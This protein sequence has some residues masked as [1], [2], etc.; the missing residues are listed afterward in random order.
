MW[1]LIVQGLNGGVVRFTTTD[2]GDNGI[3][4]STPHTH[5]QAARLPAANSVPS[6]QSQQEAA[7]GGRRIANL[8]REG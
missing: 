8:S 4:L 5:T 3:A 6:W 1:R 7:K 2:K